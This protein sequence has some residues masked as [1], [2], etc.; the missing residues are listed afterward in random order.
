MNS[1]TT[2][3][4]WAYD[5]MSKQRAAYIDAIITHGPELGIDCSKSTFCRAELRQ[6]SMK[7]KG[8]RWI[9]NWIT[10]DQDRRADVGVFHLPEVADAYSRTC[11]EAEAQFVE[12]DPQSDVEVQ[13]MEEITV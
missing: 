7:E 10:H 13:A 8:K 9:P 5:N 3:P 2:N 6:V 12:D 11:T 1:N 4:E